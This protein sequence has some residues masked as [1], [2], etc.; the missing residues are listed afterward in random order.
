MFFRG[1][2]GGAGGGKGLG[3]GAGGEGLGSGGNVEGWI[4]KALSAKH[5]GL[6]YVISYG[7]NTS[8][9]SCLSHMGMGR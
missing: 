7:R 9:I 8:C 2:V 1:T 5:P 6:V 3:E 4:K